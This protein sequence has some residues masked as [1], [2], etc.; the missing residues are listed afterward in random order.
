MNQFTIPDRFC[1]SR[2]MQNMRDGLQRLALIFTS[3]SSIDSNDDTLCCFVSRDCLKI[4]LPSFETNG[5]C[6]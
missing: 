6:M 2:R 5:W 3:D 1:I 4:Q